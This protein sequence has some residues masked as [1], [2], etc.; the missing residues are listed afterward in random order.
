MSI[1]SPHAINQSNAEFWRHV[2]YSNAGHPT[3]PTPAPEPVKIR[4][5]GAGWWMRATPNTTN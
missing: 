5:P 3:A 2:V 4:K 1:T